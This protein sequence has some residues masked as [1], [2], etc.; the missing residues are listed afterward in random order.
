MIHN[1]DKIIFNIYIV[2][3]ITYIFFLSIYSTF[4]MF[5]YGSAII[6]IEF[7]TIVILITIV[8]F[9]FIIITTLL[10]TNKNK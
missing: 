10:I 4:R 2:V 6:T 9:V 8:G 5:I 1:Q 3:S 7:I